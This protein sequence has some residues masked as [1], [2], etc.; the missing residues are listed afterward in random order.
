LPKADFG[1]LTLAKETH[2]FYGKKEHELDKA[3]D[4]EGR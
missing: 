2:A 3:L 4:L 1:W